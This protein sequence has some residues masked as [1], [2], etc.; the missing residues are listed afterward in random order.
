VWILAAPIAVQDG[1]R[2]ELLIFERCAH[3]R[4]IPGPGSLAAHGTAAARSV[5]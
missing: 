1:D 5:S 4:S 3:A 2:A